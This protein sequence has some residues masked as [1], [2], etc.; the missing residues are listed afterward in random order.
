MK[1]DD[2]ALSE[3]FNEVHRGDS[4]PS[5]DALFRAEVP[6]ARLRRRWPLLAAAAIAVGVAVAI[7][8]WSRGHS[9]GARPIT[10]SIEPPATSP[11][12]L[13]PEVEKLATSLEDWRAPTDFLLDTPGADLL[14]ETPR[15][16]SPTVV[17]WPWSKEQNL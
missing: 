12:P 10:A 17:R 1:R 5:F 16:G 2:P 11:E 7:P 3:L 9:G 15:L 8:L 14:T 4:P 13:P 6:A